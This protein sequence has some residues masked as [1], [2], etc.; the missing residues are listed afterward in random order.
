MEMLLSVSEMATKASPRSDRPTMTISAASK[1][2][3]RCRIRR[4]V[5]RKSTFTGRIVC[6]LVA[7]RRVVRRWTRRNRA[8]QGRRSLTRLRKGHTNLV[9][10][11]DGDGGLPLRREVEQE[12]PRAVRRN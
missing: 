12:R 8:A 1:A 2:D 6:P 9:D 4:A 3:P 10:V 7:R 11:A 5:D